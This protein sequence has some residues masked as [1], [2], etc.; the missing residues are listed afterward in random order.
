VNKPK[1]EQT[2]DENE[3]VGDVEGEAEEKERGDALKAR[4][5]RE[6]NPL[7]QTCLQRRLETQKLA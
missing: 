5:A 4:L 3:E 7:R 2:D 6:R 1:T